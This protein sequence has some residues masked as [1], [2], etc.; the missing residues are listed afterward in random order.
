MIALGRPLLADADIPNKIKA[1]KI[2]KIRPCLSCQEGCMGRLAS[3]ATIS[4]AV[5]PACGREKDYAL[6]KA[7]QSKKSFGDWWR[8]GRM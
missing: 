8:A 4:C 5:N 2:E 3:F 7:D 1:G 6:G